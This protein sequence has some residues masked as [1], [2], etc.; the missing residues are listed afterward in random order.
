[1]RNVLAIPYRELVPSTIYLWTGGFVLLGFL[2]ILL[3]QNQLHLLAAVVI[4]GTIFTISRVDRPTAVLVTF[5]YLFLMGDLRRIISLGEPQPAFDPMLLISPLMAAY[6]GLPQ[7]F[8]VR[9][10]DGLSKAMFALL[11]I[12]ALEVVNPLQG[13]LSVGLSG[14]FF[15][16]VPMLWFWA[17]RSLASPAVVEKLLYGVIVP[18][19]IA[20]ALLGL[21]Q[22]FFGFLPFEQAWVN[23][24]SKVYTSLYVGSSVRAFGFS[25]NAG[26]YATLLAFGTLTVISAFLASRPAWILFLPLTGTA[27]VLSSARGHMVKSVLALSVVWIMRK[28]QKVKPTTLVGMGFLGVLS[29]V[30]LSLVAAHFAPP[31]QP[32]SRKTT[33]VQNDLNHQLGGLAHPFDAN[34]STVGIHASAVGGALS[35]AAK[36]PAGYGLGYTTFAAEKLS[37]APSE[38]GSSEVDISDMF[39]AL[40]V[41]GGCTYLLAVYF[42]LRNLGRYVRSV[43]LRVG[44]PVLAIAIEMLGGW[45]AGSQYSTTA[46]LFFIFGSL[47]YQQNQTTVSIPGQSEFRPQKLLA[48]AGQE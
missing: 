30:S 15:Y 37:R 24:I 20:A 22:T 4:G 12:M 45:L 23:S 27:L 11:V 32:M 5:A 13:G 41:V 17:G 10:K 33:A 8:R 39:L 16:I 35:R 40:G 26:E 7:L 46:A 42:I 3:I 25:I 47:A 18:L 29:V 43:P 31:D 38:E 1:M 9:L 2:W 21:Y 34:H 36:N 6:L 44:L 28:G 48:A 19:A 14:A